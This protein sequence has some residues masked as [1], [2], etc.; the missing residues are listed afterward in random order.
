MS[1]IR[2]IGFGALVTIASLAL[3]EIGSFVILKTPSKEGSGGVVEDSFV[4]EPQNEDGTF[5]PTGDWVQGLDDLVLGDRFVSVFDEILQQLECLRLKRGHLRPG[6]QFEAV[7]IQGELSKPVNHRKTNP[8]LMQTEGFLIPRQG[9][10]QAASA[11]C[12]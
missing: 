4:F 11:G 12:P 9:S 7:G 1:W 5:R 6:L 10:A 8:F 2:N 3:L